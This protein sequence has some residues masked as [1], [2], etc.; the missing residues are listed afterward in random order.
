MTLL[1]IETATPMVGVALTG[2]DGSLLYAARV[3]GGRRHGELL[4]PIIAAAL[5]A[6]DLTPADLTA[7]GV[8]RGPGLFTG[9]RV[10]LATAQALSEALHLPAA[11]V[12]SLEALAHPH[13]RGR[14]LVAAVVDA[15]RHEVFWSLLAPVGEALVEVE[16]PRVATPADVAAELGKLDE[17]VLA[18]GDGARR[19]AEVLAQPG[20]EVAGPADAHP[21]PLAVAELA[22]ARLSAAAD[23]DAL[24]PLYLRQADVRIGWQERPGG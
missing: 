1:A 19:Y 22:A 11:G 12:T 18:V 14:R 21:D 16:P 5:A 7:V 13:R 24:R 23:P 17:A 15:R 9:L 10:G 8:D 3:A 20:V 4:A 6:A 2:D